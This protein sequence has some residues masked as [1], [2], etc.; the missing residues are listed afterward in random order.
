MQ[1]TNPKQF[2]TEED[3]EN[4]DLTTLVTYYN[5]SMAQKLCVCC[6]AKGHVLK[7]CPVFRMLNK[8]AKE[9]PELAISWGNKKFLSKGK[10]KKKQIQLAGNKRK[11][12]LMEKEGQLRAEEVLPF[13]ERYIEEEKLNR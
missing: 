12:K 2:F 8:R 7:T 6:D 10:I 11:A 13:S 4:D 9:L 1:R 5:L 3:L